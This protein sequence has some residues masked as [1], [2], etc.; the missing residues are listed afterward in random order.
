MLAPAAIGVEGAPVRDRG[1]KASMDAMFLDFANDAFVGAVFL[2][3]PAIGRDLK[4]H[5]LNQSL[6]F[7][8]VYHPTTVL[9]FQVDPSVAIVFVVLPTGQDVVF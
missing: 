2:V 9:Q 1:V 3:F 5:D 6:N 8:F 7:L 4:A